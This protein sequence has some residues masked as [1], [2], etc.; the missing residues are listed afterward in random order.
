M[1]VIGQ[2]LQS[3]RKSRTSDRCERGWTVV[4]LLRFCGFGGK[5]ETPTVAF[6]GPCPGK[7]FVRLARLAD[8]VC[9]CRGL[10]NRVATISVCL[11]LEA[12]SNQ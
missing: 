10:P 5:I 1:L 8:F 6:G 11:P 2:S 9:L 3:G 12:L 4:F 7:T